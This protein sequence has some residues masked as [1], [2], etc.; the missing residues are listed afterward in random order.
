ANRM[1]APYQALATADG[2]LTIGANNQ[3]LWGLLCEVLELPQLREDP[4]F[5]DNNSRMANRA[6]LVG[7]LEE[8]LA[9]AGTDEWVTRLLEAGVPAGP[10]RDYRYVLEE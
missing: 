2:Y 1:S 7:A 4:R 3:K 5:A 9:E 6:E 10:I 8:R